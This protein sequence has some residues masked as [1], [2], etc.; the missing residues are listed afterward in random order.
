MKRSRRW[1]GALTSLALICS[2]AQAPQ[3]VRAQFLVFGTQVEVLI[4][5]EDGP[6]AQAALRELGEQ[7]QRMHQNWHPWEPGALTRLNGQLATGQWATADPELLLMIRDAQRFEVSSQ[8]HFN[9]AIGELV[10]LW[11]FHTSTYPITTAPPSR[12]QIEEWRAQAPSAR[13]LSI[14]DDQVYSSN[15]SLRL[16]FSGLAKGHAARLACRT[17]LNYGLSD[18][19][20]NLGGDVMICGPGSQ[21]WAVAISDGQG[22]VYAVVELR[23]PI[24]IFSS[25]TTRRWGEWDGERYA[26]LLDP[27]SGQALDHFIQATVI[28]QDPVLA[29]AAATALAVA[30]EEHWESIAESMAVSEVLVL[31]TSGRSGSTPAFDSRLNRP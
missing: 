20:I 5:S 8:G 11:G 24:A 21:D 22:G 19:L 27:K 10:S 15:A 26:H 2:C 7:L 25:G 14:R 12:Q 4:R 9:A 13:D 31:N 30:G 28:T 17:L 18:A 6:L 16:D 29:D 1:L 3:P 23:G